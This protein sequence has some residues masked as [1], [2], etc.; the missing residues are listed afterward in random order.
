MFGWF[1]KKE[2][3]P[4][5]DGLKGLAAASI[6]YVVDK[7]GVIYIDFYWDDDVVPDA[8]DAFS[9]L[10]SQLNS[11]DLFEESMKFIEETLK[12]SGNEEEFDRFFNNMSTL[13]QAKMQ[14]FLESLGFY[15]EKNDNEVVVKPTDIANHVFRG[16][17]T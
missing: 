14:P 3:P 16:N 1:K 15:G 7:E 11:G 6:R 9:V 2:K 17:Q 4:V 5:E 10:F 8:N 13:Q 12:E